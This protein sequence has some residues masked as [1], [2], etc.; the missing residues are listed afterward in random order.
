MDFIDEYE[1]VVVPIILGDGKYLF[2][3]VKMTEM[4]LSKHDH[5]ITGL[6]RYVSNR[7]DKGKN[8]DR[9]ADTSKPTKY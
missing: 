5:L 8:T 1:L 3:D 6:C 2:K 4:K 7:Q 9:T